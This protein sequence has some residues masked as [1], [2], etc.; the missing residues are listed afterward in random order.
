LARPL[1][2]TGIEVLLRD[3]DSIPVPAAG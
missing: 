1:D 2:E 3:H